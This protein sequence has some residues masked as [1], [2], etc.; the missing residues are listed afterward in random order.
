MS[1]T[2]NH[3]A[4]G[5]GY[6][7]RSGRWADVTNPAT[8]AVT[9]KVALADRDDADHVIASA[10]LAGEQ[11]ARTSLARRTHIIFAF[12]ELL[13]SRNPNSRHSSPPSTARCTPT[14]SARSPVARR[15]WSSPAGSPTC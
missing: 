11:W 6:E 15:S 5:A 12:R 1:D 2:I 7:G 14:R 3:W 8:G 13:N 9:G 4:D 10:K